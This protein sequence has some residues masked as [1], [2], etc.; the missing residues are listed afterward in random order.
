MA[1]SS[2]LFLFISDRDGL[3]P[4]RFLNLLQH[5]GIRTVVNVAG[6]HNSLGRPE[7]LAQLLVQRQVTYQDMSSLLAGLDGTFE[8]PGVAARSRVAAI[9]AA[10][11][12]LQMAASDRTVLLSG[13]EDLSPGG[14]GATLLSMLAGHNVV[15]Q[16]L[17]LDGTAEPVQSIPGAFSLSSSPSDPLNPE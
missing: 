5:L 2:E 11:H 1:T 3:D 14:R 10:A 16:R 17:W 4:E 12:L 6:R 15:V 7:E 13:A 8:D 9:S